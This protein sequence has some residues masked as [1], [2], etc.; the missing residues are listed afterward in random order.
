MKEHLI[1]AD[2][3]VNEQHSYYVLEVRRE[4]LEEFCTVLALLKYNVIDR[5]EIRGKGGATL[6]LAH[7]NK[8]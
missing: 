5:L 7:A 6:S 4:T 8:K 2:L 3:Q 1:Q